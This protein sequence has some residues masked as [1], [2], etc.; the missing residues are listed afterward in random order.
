MGFDAKSQSSDRA[1]FGNAIKLGATLGLFPGAILGI[2]YMS[3]PPV[4]TRD[5]LLGTAALFILFS[6]LFGA[7]V[8]GFIYLLTKSASLV[9]WGLNLLAGSAV[10]I[11]IL[12]ESSVFTPV[13]VI[14]FPL[15][16]IY[17]EY[18]LK[19]LP[20]WI[21]EAIDRVMVELIV[22]IFFTGLFLLLDPLTGNSF[23][24]L[25]KPNL[26]NLSIFAEQL[27]TICRNWLHR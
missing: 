9:W 20:R 27:L 3:I 15:Y 24:E 23:S 6:S 5:E 8:G 26:G 19:N 2:V 4:T 16:L 7:L 10:S 25:V 12:L 14:V 17:R 18:L 22:A 13:S 21:S 1:S 11:C